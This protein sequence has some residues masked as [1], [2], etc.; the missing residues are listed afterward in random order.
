MMAHDLQREAL[1]SLWAGFGLTLI[2]QPHLL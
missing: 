2:L 1:H